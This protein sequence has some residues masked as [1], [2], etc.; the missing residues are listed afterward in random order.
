VKYNDVHAEWD[1][2]NRLVFPELRSPCIRHGVEFIGIDLRWGVTKKEIEQRGALSV[3]LDEIRRCNLFVS[4][5]GDRYGWIPVPEEIPQKSFDAIREVRDLAVEDVSLLL[6]WYQL[7]ETTDPPVY[8]LRHDQ[9][10]PDDVSERLIR[11]W[12]ATGLPHAGDSIIAE[13]AYPAAY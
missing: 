12:E 1:Y 5:I 9:E 3:C 4:L 11:L 6:E 2:L 8:H 7:D 10:V 13:G